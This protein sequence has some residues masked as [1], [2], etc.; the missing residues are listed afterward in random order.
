MNNRITEKPNKRNRLLRFSERKPIS[1]ELF[2]S[3]LNE[4]CAEREYFERWQKYSD[5]EKNSILR[6]RAKRQRKLS[7]EII[8][9]LHKWQ[10]FSDYKG[11]DHIT[12]SRHFFNY[13]AG[14]IANALDELEKHNIVEYEIRGNLIIRRLVKPLWK[15]LDELEALEGLT[16]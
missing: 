1:D 4:F 10:I 2:A 14:A 8:E 3:L 6:E 11:C 5:A 15:S 13:T 12:F 7:T 9:Y 16:R